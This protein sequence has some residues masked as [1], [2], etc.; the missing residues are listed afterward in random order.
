[1]INFEL[2]EDWVTKKKLNSNINLYNKEDYKK[3]P[4]GIMSEDRESRIVKAEEDAHGGVTLEEVIIDGKE[5]TF[6]RTI[7]GQYAPSRSSFEKWKQ[8]RIQKREKGEIKWLKNKEK[9]KTTSK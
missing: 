6:N 9:E 4:Y 3:L 5:D 7:L 2:L 1:M 8:E